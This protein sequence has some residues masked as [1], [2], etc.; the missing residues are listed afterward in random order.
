MRGCIVSILKTPKGRFKGYVW[1]YPNEHLMD[2]RGCNFH[3]R[4]VEGQPHFGYA[5]VEECEAFMRAKFPNKEVLQTWAYCG[6][7]SFMKE[8]TI[9]REVKSLSIPEKS[10]S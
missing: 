8:G 4:S 10:A 7:G 3:I 1:G 6:D 5:T 9:N 2:W